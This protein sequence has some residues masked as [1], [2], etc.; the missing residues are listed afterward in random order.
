LKHSIVAKLEEKKAR[1]E[2]PFI[3]KLGFWFLVSIFFFFVVDVM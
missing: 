3:K 2:N 1:Q